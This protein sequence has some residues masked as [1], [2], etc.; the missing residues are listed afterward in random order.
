[1]WGGNHPAAG[2]WFPPLAS[3]TA[4]PSRLRPPLCRWTGGGG[5]T[6]AASHAR[7][8]EVP[9]SGV[10]PRSRNVKPG[11]RRGA[12][13]LLGLALGARLLAPLAQR[14]AQRELFLRGALLVRAGRLE[15]HRQA[16]E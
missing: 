16:V 3:G 1:M 10:S 5:R 12:L 9:A 15:D 11:G 13:L 2:E 4:I 7:T 14:A 6:H 8:A